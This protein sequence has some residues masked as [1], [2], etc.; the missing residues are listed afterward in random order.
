MPDTSR[1]AKNAPTVL[2][3]LSALEQD[4]AG[5]AAVDLA[6]FLFHSG[7]H[8]V[9]ASPTGPATRDL[10]RTGAV[11]AP[12][13]LDQTGP[14]A[15]LANGRRL[16]R[17]ARDHGAVIVHA[18]DT[19]AVA[20]G[21]VLAKR[22]GVPL[23]A[24][25]DP[26]EYERVPAVL[27]QADRVVATSDFAADQAKAALP[28]DTDIR[29]VPRG[30]DLGVF[31][32]GAVNGRRLNALAERWH[33]E[34]DDRVLLVPSPVREGGGHLLLLR[35]LARLDRRDFLCLMVGDADPADG[36]VRQLQALLETTGLAGQVRLLGPCDDMPA[37]Y[38]LADLVCLPATDTSISGRAAIEAQA[39]GVPVVVTDTGALG[40]CLLPYSTGWLVGPDAPEELAE[41]LAL[42]LDQPQNVRQR[43]AERA[44]AFVERQLSA[45]QSGRRML[46]IYAELLLP[47]GSSAAVA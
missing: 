46:Q 1:P 22:A 37:A 23:V 25:A 17:L 45:E 5:K 38:R 14:I 28:A 41:A 27:A 21:Y 6:R 43:V 47:D 36:Q 9:V 31:D 40:E 4:D 39:M 19:G 8:V 33:V 24:S 42:A 16:A 12:V 34:P 18:I 13:A 20:A 15:R 35:A 7:C 32:P 11:H 30:V 3:L 29:T 44:R 2:L 26:V 10:L